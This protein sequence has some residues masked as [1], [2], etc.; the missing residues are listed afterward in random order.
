MSIRICNINVAK[1]IALQEGTG[2]EHI[3]P[4]KIYNPKD[5]SLLAHDI[6]EIRYDLGVTR[7]CDH[8]GDGIKIGL[9][10]AIL[11][12]TIYLNR[13]NDNIHIFLAKNEEDLHKYLE[14]GI[15]KL[16]ELRQASANLGLDDEFWVEDQIEEWRDNYQL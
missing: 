16:A 14:A 8:Y 13:H 9:K 2:W 3:T 12:A 15:N 10:A 5:L 7:V 11:Q 4:T 1:T 6:T